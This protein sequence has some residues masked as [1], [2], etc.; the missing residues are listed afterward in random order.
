MKSSAFSLTIT[1]FLRSL[2][3]KLAIKFFPRI[4]INEESSSIA[5]TCFAF[6]ASSIVRMPRPGPI[7]MMLSFLLSL[8]ACTMC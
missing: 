1:I 6:L 8:A 3:C 5:V 2:P 4:E 7:S